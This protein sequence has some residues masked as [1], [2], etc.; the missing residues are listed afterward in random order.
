MNIT[1][2]HC[3]GQFRIPDEKVPKGQSFSLGCPKC[4]EKIT[5]GAPQPAPAK[6]G[7]SS[8]PADH[9]ANQEK[10]GLV[11]DVTSG[12]YNDDDRPFDFLEEG[13][14]TA[15]LCELDPV[16]KAKIK[17]AL[18]GMGYLITE[19]GTAREALKQMR[20]HVFDMVVLNETFDTDDPE[21]NHVLKFLSRMAMYTRRKVFVALITEAYRTMDNMAAFAKSVNIIINPNSIDDV[22]K[23][24]TR[25]FAENQ[26]F[27]KVYMQAMD[28]AGKL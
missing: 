13:T 26:A 21:S 16:Y 5:V 10:S 20:F 23:I 18:T 6:S 14:R 27:Y 4:K 28:S 22:D 15:L 25:A 3:K 19:P 7:S 17:D 8:K 2:Q 1:C 11:E 9:P 12:G 24:L